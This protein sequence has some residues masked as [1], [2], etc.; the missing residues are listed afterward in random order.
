MRNI[1]KTT[2]PGIGGQ[3]KILIPKFYSSQY[4]EENK[5]M[6]C[7]QWFTRLPCGLSE[8]FTPL[9]VQEA[10]FS[11]LAS[12]WGYEIQPHSS[13]LSSGNP[14]D[15]SSM[16]TA[17]GIAE[18]SDATFSIRNNGA[19]QGSKLVPNVLL[20]K[21]YNIMYLGFRKKIPHG[22]SHAVI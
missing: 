16:A 7:L 11:P 10:R 4:K 2:L 18:E 9:P 22:S 14:Q 21:C 19:E 8:E 20:I 12:S 17:H 5:T 3:V 1:F 13:G 6:F 15:T